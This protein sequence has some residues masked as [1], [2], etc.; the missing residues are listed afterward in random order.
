MSYI[1]RKWVVTTVEIVR[2]YICGIALFTNICSQIWSGC[3]MLAFLF[4]NPP[5]LGMPPTAA[6][7]PLHYNNILPGDKPFCFFSCI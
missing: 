5:I 4:T 2:Y 1:Y 3:D 7:P 6:L